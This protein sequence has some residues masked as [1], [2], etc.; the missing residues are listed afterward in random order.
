MTNKGDE[1][2][3]YTHSG[4]IKDKVPFS[5]DMIVGD[6]YETVANRFTGVKVKLNPV[7]VA[8]YDVLMGSYNLHLQV[9]QSN[10]EQ[11]REL[12]NDFNKGKNWFIE[13]NSQ[14]YFD[15]ID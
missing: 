8:V 13:N 2:D 5:K 10:I 3:I 12:Y 7:E 15:L 14:A 1:W 4:Y 9:G 6:E 11:S